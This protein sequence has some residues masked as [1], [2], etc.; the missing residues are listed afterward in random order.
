MA[1]GESKR[2]GEPKQLL[3]WKE[4]TLLGQSIQVAKS[5]DMENIYVVLGSNFQKI[6]ALKDLEGIRIVYN[7]SYSS[8]QGSSLRTG[9]D[10]LGKQRKEYN[11]VLV[12]LCDQPL[13][14][15]EYLNKIIKAFKEGEKGI[16][17]TKYD[18]KAG[19]PAVFHSKYF[20]E[21]K[22]VEGDKGAKKIIDENRDDVLLF[23]AGDQVHDVDT[24]SEYEQLLN[25]LKN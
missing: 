8:G 19:V 12:M 24:K 20:E 4:T 23:D 25:K 7:P 17:A 13:I 5:V 1:A 2:M 10:F 15:R 9:I 11:A 22:K 6:S 16:V 18:D 14:T 21:L 3:P